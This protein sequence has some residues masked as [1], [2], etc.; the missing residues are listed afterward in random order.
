MTK[1]AKLQGFQFDEVENGVETSA[2]IARR[3][4]ERPARAGLFE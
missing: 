3:E 2:A 4:N 1:S